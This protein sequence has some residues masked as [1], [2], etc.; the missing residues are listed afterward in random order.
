VITTWP[1]LFKDILINNILSRKKREQLDCPI[2]LSPKVKFRSDARRSNIL[3]IDCSRCGQFGLSPEFLW[4]DLTLPSSQIANASKWVREYRQGRI[5]RESDWDTLLRLQTPTVGEKA[6]KLIRYLS[7]KY[8]KIGTKIYLEAMEIK[9]QL[10]AVSWAEDEDELRYLLFDYLGEKGFIVADDG[11]KYCTIS[12][13][14]W[15][16][17][18]KK[19]QHPNSEI[20]FCAMWF[21][22]S[23]QPIW[24]E[25]ISLAIE[26][27]GYTPKIMNRHQHNNRIDDE[28]I[29][30]I[31]RSRFLVADFTHG[32]DGDRGGVYFEAGFALGL[33]LQV[34]HTCRKDMIK[35]NKIHF[36]THGRRINCRSLGR[37]FKIA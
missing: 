21:D 29:A 22:P 10:I 30:M 2:C 5:L 33:G 20:G 1:S 4:S 26:A 6:E 12:P 32:E 31:R 23:I 19:N 13:V 27:A 8:T 16:Y 37:S 7:Q 25:A 18:S 28:I 15:D 11:K 24:D 9:R 34:I 17:L 35:E 36:D 14:G 3:V